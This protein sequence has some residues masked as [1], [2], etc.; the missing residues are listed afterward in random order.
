VS[1]LPHCI[2]YFPAERYLREDAFLAIKTY[3]SSAGWSHHKQSQTFFAHYVL[4]HL[5]LLTTPHIKD[6]HSLHLSKGS[7]AM[8]YDMA[9]N[10]TDAFILSL[11]GEGMGHIFHTVIIY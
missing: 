1:Q 11:T 10:I 6:Y 4:L 7:T 5:G 8:Y 2:Y 9:N 3:T